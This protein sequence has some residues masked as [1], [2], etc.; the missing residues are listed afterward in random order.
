MHTSSAIR[1]ALKKQSMQMSLQSWN[2]GENKLKM[3]DGC[4]IKPGNVQFFDNIW[5]ILKMVRDEILREWENSAI[6]VAARV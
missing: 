6:S 4:C 1:G 3:V 2:D 5:Q